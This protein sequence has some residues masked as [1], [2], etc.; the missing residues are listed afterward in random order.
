[1]GKWGLDREKTRIEDAITE[2]QIVLGG[3]Y[4][5]LEEVLQA[6]NFDQPKLF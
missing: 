6:Q 3:L 2:E 5:R 1:M 4:T